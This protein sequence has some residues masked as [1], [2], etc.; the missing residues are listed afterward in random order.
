MILVPHKLAKFTDCFTKFQYL[1]VS[2]LL[3]T[4]VWVSTHLQVTISFVRYVFASQFKQN[5]SISSLVYIE[6]DIAT[7][8]CLAKNALAQ[9]SYFFVGH[10]RDS[11]S[12]GKKWLTKERNKVGSVPAL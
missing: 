3:F 10:V 12:K 8:D 6:I 1:E 9:T 11:C 2:C 5:N 4:Q 7:K